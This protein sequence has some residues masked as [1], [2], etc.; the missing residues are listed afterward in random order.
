MVA[1]SCTIQ[2]GERVMDIVEQL[3]WCGLGF[4]KFKT[5]RGDYGICD[6]AADEIERLREALRYYADKKEED[7]KDGDDGVVA[8]K[9]LG[10]KE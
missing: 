8:R 9:A 4:P 5:N 10:E 3:R 2:E 6:D 1:A 7:W